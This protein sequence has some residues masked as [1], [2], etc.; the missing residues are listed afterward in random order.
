MDFIKKELEMNFVKSCLSLNYCL[1]LFFSVFSPCFSR[2]LEQDP[3]NT[4]ETQIKSFENKLRIP[5]EQSVI[6]KFR[7]F[8]PRS[9][10][11][12][13]VIIPSYCNRRWYKKNLDSIFMQKY[14]NY[15]IIYI[16]D[17]SPDGTGD[18][19]EEYVRQRNQSH[20]VTVIKNEKRACSLANIYKAVS[21]C[22]DSWIVASCDGDDWWCSVHV[23][24]TLNKI[25]QAT[26]A[27]V[28]YGNLIHVPGNEV[29]SKKRVPKRIIDKN[30]FRTYVWNYSGLRTYPVWLF[31]KIKLE[32]LLYED[33][34]ISSHGDGA[35]FFPLLEMA[36]KRQFFIPDIFYVANRATG[37]ND[38][39]KR[40]F[41]ADMEKVVK[42][43]T[44]Y[45]PLFSGSYN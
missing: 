31:K 8:K 38:F 17:A 43:K 5:K 42:N 15:N 40:S 4:T 11:H 3:Y 13:V 2:A 39:L 22:D 23:L 1:L 27:W 30:S 36:G 20:R 12:F 28:T 24:E 14:E 21:I 33:N 18:L 37:L 26:D 7:N 45:K 29:I 32:D 10:L 19:V 6:W 44:K 9:E 34:F 25:Y 16:D 35:Y 41:Q